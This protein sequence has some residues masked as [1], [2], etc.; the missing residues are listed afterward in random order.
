MKNLLILLTLIP[1][2]CFAQNK[3]LSIFDNL[4]GKTWVAEG[5]WQ[6]GNPFKQEKTF[7]YSLDS[8]IVIANTLGFIDKTQTKFGKRNFGIRQYDKNSDS[9]RFWEFDVFGGLNTGTVLAEG[10]NLFYQYEYGGMQLTNMWEFVNDRIYNFK[11][12]IRKNGR[13]AKLFLNTKFISSE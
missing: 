2:F 7:E 9:I 5:V 8:T 10:K 6:N 4:V 3:R 12:G 13:W 11:V 1:V